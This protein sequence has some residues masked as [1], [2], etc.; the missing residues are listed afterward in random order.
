MD[1]YSVKEIMSLLPK[2]N[3]YATV[4]ITYNYVHCESATEEIQNNVYNWVKS[5]F[6]R[7]ARRV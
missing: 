4:V 3:R 1:I 7:G 6:D 5:V 2:E